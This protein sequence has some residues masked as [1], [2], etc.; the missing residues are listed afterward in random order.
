MDT[1]D[2]LKA[3][4][5]TIQQAKMSEPVKNYLNILKEIMDREL[6]ASFNLRGEEAACALAKLQGMSVALNLET[7]FDGTIAAYTKQ[8]SPIVKLGR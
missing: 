5:A 8:Q 4:L 2:S 3:K 6:F 1:I 7:I